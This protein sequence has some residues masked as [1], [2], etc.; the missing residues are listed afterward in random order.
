MQISE[1]M[2]YLFDINF[3][4]ILYRLPAVFIGFSFHE[5][6]H[7]LVAYRMGDDTAKINGRLTLD[8]TAHIDPIGIL[9]LI[10]FKFGWAKPVPIN[11]GNFKN[12]KQGIILVS[13]A[14]PMMNFIIAIISLLI[15]GLVYFKF[16]I[17]NVIFDR[18]MI[19]IYFINI[20]LGIFNLIPLPPLD[21]SKILA[22][23]LPVKLEYKFYQ[24][25]QYSYILLLILILTNVIDYILSPMFYYAEKLISS[26]VSLFF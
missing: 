23:I 19:N 10:L 9:M 24:Y 18:I 12:R 2:I 16:G 11:P 3:M 5:F 22:G 20:G 8:P 7:A 26:I 4:E 25:E 6:A 14:G 13:L 17:E 15:Y 21:G 1:G